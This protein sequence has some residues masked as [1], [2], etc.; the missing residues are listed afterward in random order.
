MVVGDDINKSG[1]DA[2]KNHDDID[3]SFE[4]NLSFGDTLYWRP[5][6]T[7]GSPI[8]TILNS[9]S[10]DLFAGAIYAK[11]AFEMW[12][13]LKETYD[14]VDG[15]VLFNLHKSLDESYLA[16][17]SNILTREP[18]P[19]LNAAFAV[20]SGEESHRN[21]TIVGATKPTATAFATKTFDNKRR[22]NNNSNFNRGS[23]SNSN[24]NNRGPN[25]NLKCNIV[26]RLV[27]LLIDVLSFVSSNNATTSNSPVSLSNEQLSKLMSL[28][29]NNGVSYA[30]ANMAEY[31]VSLW[32]VHKIARDS[33]FFVRF[34][35][36]KCYIEDLRVNK[37]VGIGNQCNGLYMFDV[38][39]ACKFVSN[40][41]IS[42]CFV[43]KSLWHQRLGYP[44]DQVLNV[45]TS[46]L[47]LDSQS[48]FD[49][50][51]DTCNKAKQIREPFSLSDHKST[52][53]GQLVQ[54]DVWGPYKV[55]SRDGFRY[56]L[57]IVDDF[58]RAVWVY[59]L[60]EKDDVYNSIMSFVQMLTN[61]FETNI[62][63]F[64]SDNG[65]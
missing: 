61:Q 49:H 35:D 3:S 30:Y 2:N 20:V 7:G 6:Y 46:T 13:D 52:K 14:K 53:I 42:S 9:L 15:P 18:L 23:D 36:A 54:I 16:I 65:T 37:T 17:R 28:L 26:K 58:S 63:V 48:V 40:N 47:Y 43:S 44:A 10:P 11:S 60:K 4:V 12:S 62:N 34:D 25:H 38:D 55:V 1:D 5:N 8:V 45:L 31:T 57:T 50:L 24:S 32:S 56:F 27:I 29:N 21:V 51:C 41:C 39:N 22:P 59:M 19:L 33:K 64:R